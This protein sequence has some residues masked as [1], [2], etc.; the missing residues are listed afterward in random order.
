M[1]YIILITLFFTTLGGR[2]AIQNGDN[3]QQQKTIIVYGSDTCH[4]CMDTKAYLKARKVA[5]IYFD[6]D[7]NQEKQSEMLVK[8]KKAYIPVS[9][10]SLP[11]IDKG[12]AIFTNGVDFNKFLKRIIE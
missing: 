3:L 8:L 2:T 5:F 12:G 4:Y 6:V 7:K 9:S 10:L 11:V 1:K